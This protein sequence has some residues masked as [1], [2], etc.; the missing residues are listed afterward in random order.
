MAWN[1]SRAPVGHTCP[2][3]DRVLDNVQE[4]IRGAEYIKSVPEDDSTSEVIDIM[5]HLMRVVDEMEDI[6]NANSELRGWGEDEEEKVNSLEG[7][8]DDLESERDRLRDELNMAKGEIQDL[9]CRLSS[10]LAS[11]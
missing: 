8:R 3:I 1:N 11:V 5:H 6:R 7:E 4:A 10:E 9:G 2:T